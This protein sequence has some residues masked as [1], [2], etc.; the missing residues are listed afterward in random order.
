MK[1]TGFDW[2]YGNLNKVKKHGLEIELI[3]EF[4]N[5]NPYILTDEKHNFLESRF[6]A[7]GEIHERS[8]KIRVISARFAHKKEVEKFYE[9]I[10]NQEN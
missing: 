9:K 7:F 1:L 3:E 10:K 2:G 4:L 5:S 8:L 6:I